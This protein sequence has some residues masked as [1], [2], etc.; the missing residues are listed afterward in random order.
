V[1][2]TR[3]DAPIHVTDANFE[4]AVLKSALP[5]VVDFWAPWCGPCRMVGPVLEKMAGD[6]AG[7]LIV[8]K[9][10]VDD[11]QQQAGHYG[12]QGIPTLLFVKDGEIVDTV[13]GFRPE[14]VIKEMVEK[15]LEPLQVC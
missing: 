5:V 10:N 3:I 15:M 1:N 6:Y 7:R 2:E 11:E 14:A 8:A 12:V 9:V 4:K 13:V